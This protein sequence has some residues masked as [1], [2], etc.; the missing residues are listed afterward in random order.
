MTYYDEDMFVLHQ[1]KTIVS[2]SESFDLMTQYLSVAIK[3]DV[4]IAIV[5]YGYEFRAKGELL[6]VKSI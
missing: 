6:V 1:E 2:H 3:N 4:D 5:T